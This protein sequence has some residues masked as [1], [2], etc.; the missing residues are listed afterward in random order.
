MQSRPVM[1]TSSSSAS[2]MKHSSKEQVK[3]A[4]RARGKK[5]AGAPV[6]YNKKYMTIESRQDINRS[7]L[8]NSNRLLYQTRSNLR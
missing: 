6:Q 4:S 1:R 7:V 2:R 5:T 3:Q 8:G